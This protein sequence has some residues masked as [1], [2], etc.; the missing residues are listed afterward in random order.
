MR[1]FLFLI[2]ILSTSV[3]LQAK[4]KYYIAAGPTI[5]YFITDNS[6]ISYFI[7]RGYFRSDK[8]II[9]RIGREIR[10]DS[11]SEL[12]IGIGFSTRA[13]TLNNLLVVPDISKTRHVYF[14]DI[15]SRIGYLEIP[16]L[17]KLRLP[18]IKRVNF[19]PIFGLSLELPV[20]DLT[21]LSKRRYMG[22]FTADMAKYASV[23]PFFTKASKFAKNPTK[24]INYFG[25]QLKYSK[26]I[27]ELSWAVDNQ[28][29]YLFDH[30]TSIKYKIGS[31]NTLFYVEF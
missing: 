13:A 31:F 28:G 4:D 11:F 23:Y 14:W 1:K 3:I 16:I 5:S 26:Y 9:L 12:Y 18:F 2:F 25:F 29:N 27:F 20:K 6:N 19:G 8:G 15:H 30:L 21:E 7:N 10:S 17:I 24:I 22:E